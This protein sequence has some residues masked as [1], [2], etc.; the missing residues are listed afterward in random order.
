MAAN[1]HKLFLHSWALDRPFLFLCQTHC[2][3]TRSRVERNP[4]MLLHC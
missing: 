2:C 1:V 3:D 4:T